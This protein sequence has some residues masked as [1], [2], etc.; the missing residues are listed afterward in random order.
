[1]HAICIAI[2]ISNVHRLD[3]FSYIFLI[4]YF[5]VY[6]YYY[7]LL[8]TRTTFYNKYR[9]FVL[10]TF[11]AK[12]ILP[13]CDLLHAIFQLKKKNKEKGRVHMYNND[14]EYVN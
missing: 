3:V 11:L 4:W 9:L 7:N 2:D 14:V 6:L 13:M 12:A 5:M 10:I 1:M 8:F